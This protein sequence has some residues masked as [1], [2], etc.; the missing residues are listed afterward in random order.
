MRR[1]QAWTVGALAVL[2]AGAPPAGAA[3]APDANLVAARAA[4]QR[5][6]SATRLPP[7]AVAQAT[8]PSVGGSLG[9]VYQPRGADEVIRSQYWV[10]SAAPDSVN[11]YIYRHPPAGSRFYSGSGPPAPWATGWQEERSFRGQTGRLTSELLEIT[12]ASA[13]GGATAI[14]ADA[15]VLWRPTWEEIPASARAARVQ[16][17]GVAQRTV[18]GAGLARL[19]A[20]VRT[21]PVVA[22]GP[23]ACPAGRP[24]QAIRVTFVDAH[25]RPVAHIGADSADGCV[26][27]AVTVG[28]RR[29][30]ALQDG[31]GLAPRLWAVGSLIRCAAGQLA[32]SVGA[33]SVYPSQATATIRLRNVA[34]APC[35]LKG[36]ASI[37]LLTATG[38]RLP[39][40]VRRTEGPS[41]VVTAAGHGTLSAGVSWRARPL[42]CALP[43]PASAIVGVPGI[44]H[45]FAVTL[46]SSRHRLG[47]CTGQ[48]S[49]SPMGWS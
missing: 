44:R 20:L 25:G 37:E 33:P 7:G 30:P 36:F 32:V 49:V 24:G 13:R 8:D 9:Q 35:S 15:I 23:Y 14:R 40:S 42:R 46:A 18:T 27:L 45:R 41:S 38:R 10:V 3:G 39:V 34:G 28:A 1:A 29:G 43:P 26:W 31:W 11:A 21:S 4:A 16:L 17:D 47:P 48:V 19:R 5:I 2:A 22:P 12:T 6:L